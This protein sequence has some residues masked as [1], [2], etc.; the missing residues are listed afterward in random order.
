MPGRETD[1]REARGAGADDASEERRGRSLRLEVV[2]L[3]AVVA[4]IRPHRQ[5][6]TEGREHER[7]ERAP[8]QRE[9]RAASQRIPARLRLDLRA[10]RRVE[11]PEGRSF[12]RS[13]DGVARSG[14]TSSQSSFSR[15]PPGAAVLIA[16]PSSSRSPT[17][18][19]P[20]DP[21]KRSTTPGHL[22]RDRLAG[23]LQRQDP[24]DASCE[25][26][27]PRG[28]ENRRRRV[29]GRLRARGG[30]HLAE[31][32]QRHA[33]LDSVGVELG[34]T[35][36]SPS[37]SRSCIA[38]GPERR[39]VSM[40]PFPA[41]APR[42]MRRGGGTI[43]EPDE[44]RT[45]AA[46]A[47]EA[48][49]ARSGRRLR[50]RCGGRSRPSS[51]TIA[52]ND[53]MPGETPRTMR[54]SGIAGPAERDGVAGIDERRRA[55]RCHFPDAHSGPPYADAAD[56]VAVEARARSRRSHAPRA[57]RSSSRGG[58]DGRS[59]R[60]PTTVCEPAVAERH[61]RQ[62]TRF[63]RSSRTTTSSGTWNAACSRSARLSVAR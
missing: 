28:D 16:V 60:L 57:R 36:P 21:G 12:E 44:Q 31:E 7:D 5:T 39:S 61:R 49:A 1:D 59:P 27:E 24:A 23:H 53:T 40:N 46:R 63:W 62:R 18:V 14:A 47:R 54:S 37:Q 58:R 3:A 33:R 10:H 17:T 52:A 19:S 4:K 9:E 11:R 32:R 34:T 55:R 48:F 6:E 20:R 22:H 26:G 8:D 2:V 56:R 13:G 35:P 43:C 51:R 30:K 25:L 42:S 38:S 50:A 15:A 45:C 41:S 29:V